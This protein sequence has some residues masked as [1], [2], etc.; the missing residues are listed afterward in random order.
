MSPKRG[1]CPAHGKVGLSASL[2]SA[3]HTIFTYAAIIFQITTHLCSILWCCVLHHKMCWNHVGSYILQ[4]LVSSMQDKYKVFFLIHSLCKL[5][6]Q[7]G[8]LHFFSQQI[9]KTNSS[10]LLH[11]IWLCFL[12]YMR[13]QHA[14]LSLRCLALTWVIWPLEKSKTS[15]LSSLRMTMLFWQRLSLVR[16]AP[17]MSLMKVGQ[18]L[19]HS[20]FKICGK[21]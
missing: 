2:F 10:H 21:I 16:L 11:L 7:L 3:D 4:N 6:G 19:G 17:T 13:M 15:S 5:V 8:Q 12:R 1:N 18:C 20:C 9:I 14:D